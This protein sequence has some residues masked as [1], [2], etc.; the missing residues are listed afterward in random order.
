MKVLVTGGAGFVGSHLVDALVAQGHRVRVLDNLDPQVHGEGAGRP[1]YLHA[2]AEL[3]VGDVRDRKALAR[4]LDG[5]EV[6]F[7]QA[8]AVGVGQSM[9]EMEHYVSVNSVGAAVLLEEI[10]RRKD[11]IQKM[12]V[13]SSMSIYGE[14]AYQAPDG[15]MVF[16]S[17]R[18]EEEMAAGRFDLDEAGSALA[19]V[20]T[21][22][23]KPLLP[24][25][26]YAITKRDHEEMFLAVGA[27]Y[28]IPAVALRY[29]NIYGTRQ[30]LNNPYTGVMAI[31]SSRILNR[32]R[33]MIFEDGLQ[34]R[35]FVHVSDIVQANLL[36]MERE[37][38]NGR[39]YNV[40]T[41]RATSVLQVADLL[42]EQLDF[43]EP[44]DVVGKYRAGD[45][46]HCYADIGRIGKQL[47]YT[48]RMSLEDG[49]RE[50]L[51]WLRHQKAEDRVEQAARELEARGLTR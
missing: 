15:R 49:M 38:A 51:S 41:G 17:L 50:L 40:G 9:Y 21:P 8:A 23:T 27:A 5:I 42:A 31:F 13:A 18:S 28:E 25:S 30:S 7:H 11:Q 10:V 26:I 43:P 48:P 24:T 36:A 44:A 46:R 4:A 6:V 35:D 32:H 14:G 45:I 29:F 37:E 19:P 12:V 3:Q 39:V 20:P 34:S 2:D 1:D 22:E 47:G 16:P 33:P